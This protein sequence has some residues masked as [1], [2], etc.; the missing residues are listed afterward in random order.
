MKHRY[1]VDSGGKF[2][3]SSGKDADTRPRVIKTWLQQVVDRLV[4]HSPRLV[5]AN[6]NERFF[7]A[8]IE[9]KISHGGIREECPRCQA[10]SF[11]FAAAETAARPA[12]RH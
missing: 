6:C 9:V 5:C 2:E 12:R 3:P 8:E 7:A 11:H 4:A 1:S 10:G